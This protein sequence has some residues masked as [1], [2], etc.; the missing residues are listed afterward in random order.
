MFNSADLLAYWESQGIDP[1]R[2]YY[3]GEAL[4][5]CWHLDHMTPLCRGGTHTVGNLVPCTAAV[6]LSKSDRTADEYM[7]REWVAA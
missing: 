4:G 6:N 1:T 5:E 2:C 7:D 3:T